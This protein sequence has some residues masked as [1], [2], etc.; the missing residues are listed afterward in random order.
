VAVTGVTPTNLFAPVTVR[1]N[2][3][4]IVGG[5][6]FTVSGSNLYAGAEVYLRG[7]ACS[8][9]PPSLCT[10]D[11]VPAPL[12]SVAPDGSSLVAAIPST[13]AG[14]ETSV[15]P[16]QVVVGNPSYLTTGG[17]RWTYGPGV[18]IG[19][20]PW[21]QLNG[22]SFLNED[23]GP[24]VEEFEAC[25]ESSIFTPLGFRDPYYGLWACVYLLM[26]DSLKGS[27]Y[28]FSGT[29]ALMADGSLSRYAYDQPWADGVRGVRY[30][31]G[32]LGLAP[33]M[34]GTNV[35]LENLCAPK[36]YRWTGFDLVQPYRS[37]NLWGR[38]TSLAGAQTSAEA[39][40][41]SLSQLG[42][43][44]PFGARR[45][46][47]AG[48]PVD[49]LTRVRAAP[50]QYTLCVQKRDFGD[51]HCVTPFAVVDG[52]GLDATAS[53]PVV[54]TNKSLIK[55]YDNNHVGQERFIEVN[56]T[57]N[58]FRY[59]SGGD[60]VGIYEGP[61]LF[62]TP[63]STYRG[64]RHALD[65]F[66][67]GRYGV[68]YLR[69]LMSGAASASMEASG[70]GRAGWTPAG[71]T[72]SYDGSLTYVPVGLLPDGTGSPW[73]TTMFFLPQTNAPTT[74]SLRSSG[75]NVLLYA[76]MGWG[77][78][79]FGFSAGDTGVTHAVD[80]LVLKPENGLAS[81]GL[82]AA[83]P[84]SAFSVMTAS[85]DSNGQSRVLLLDA[86]A[87]SVSPDLLVERDGLRDVRVRNRGTA[88]L[89]FRVALAGADAAGRVFDQVYGSLVLP[90]KATLRLVFPGNVLSP[91]L[92][93]ELDINSD[94]VPEEVESLGGSG[95]VRLGREGGLLALRW[96]DAGFGG[97][98]ET[99]PRVSPASWSPANAAVT[100]EGAD[101]V[102]R[103]TPGATG[104]VFRVRFPGTNCVSF[105]AL[106]TGPRP[107]PWST[108]GFTL[109]A[110]GVTGA[111]SAQN[112]VTNRSG[113]TGLDVAQAVRV[114]PPAG[115]G[116]LTLEVFNPQG[117]VE[118]EAVGPLGAVLT[119]QT[120]AASA[121]GPQSVTLRGYRGTLQFVRVK[122]PD[123]PA[124][125][126]GVCAELAAP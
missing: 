49:V 18:S 92:V 90:D 119:R 35:S 31:N 118:V 25:Y 2:P 62:Y 33:C 9:I 94:G 41:G 23:D 66:S 126:R 63:L 16:F 39:I 48:N 105:A 56:R 27:C 111:L 50:G 60:R 71:L 57:L 1:T 96:R 59:N 72:N 106:A 113:Y 19:P 87:G 14:V 52:L 75:S 114:V 22:F 77:D 37:L 8:L 80:G 46:L 121:N 40:G 104:A 3:V 32:Y 26:M 6:T 122:A 86:G 76:A 34:I 98:L 10:S 79:A 112:M 124:L 17:N 61:A 70:G 99:S 125:L 109:E 38:I 12:V 82:H 47:A 100:T 108:N 93:R 107:N 81:L 13:L 64:P 53:L 7:P 74:G 36:P 91:T 116:G 21:P 28:G 68:D 51:G 103:V 5:G 102:A 89:T 42:I 45:G 29:S 117:P 97:V 24:S 88:P 44:T 110:L 115:A 101:R 123:K 11:W 58:A 120:V 84:V 78:I 95:Q 73:D 69:L 4:R 65:P 30:A 67:L 85:R 54:D 15:R 83:G 20:P 55:I 43:P